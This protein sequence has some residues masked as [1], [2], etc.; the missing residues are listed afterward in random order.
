LNCLRTFSIIF[1]SFFYKCQKNVIYWVKK[2][3]H[4]IQGYCNNKPDCY[5]AVEKYIRTV[6]INKHLNFKVRFL[7]IFIK[8]KND[9]V[10]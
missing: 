3:K 6:F 4:L 10:V 5:I 2:R 7:I 9:F 8:F 1:F